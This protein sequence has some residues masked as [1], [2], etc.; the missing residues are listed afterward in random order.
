MDYLT[1]EGANTL[2]KTIRD[3]WA[4]QGRAVSLTIEEFRVRDI[5]RSADTRGPLYAIRSTMINGTPV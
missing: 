3:Y 4:K 1:R 2:A 5:T